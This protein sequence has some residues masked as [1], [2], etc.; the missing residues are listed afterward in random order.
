MGASPPMRQTK[1]L[2]RQK[3]QQKQKT[4]KNRKIAALRHTEMVF[5]VAKLNYLL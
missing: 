2:I 1:K 3:L 4:Q 5:K